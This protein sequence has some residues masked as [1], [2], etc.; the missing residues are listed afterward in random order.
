MQQS[1]VR[2]QHSLALLILLALLGDDTLDAQGT[3]LLRQPTVS[4]SSIAFTYGAD[5]WIVGRD[6][7]VARRLT[8]TPAVESDPHLSP[9]G[10]TVAFTSTR[11]GSPAVYTLPIEGGQPA[12]LTWHS[13]PARVRGWSPDGE[14]V[15]YA[16][17]RGTAP[18]GYDRLWTVSRNGG[19]STLLPAPF[20]HKASY[21]PDGATALSWTRSA[22]GT[23]SGGT[24]EADRTGRW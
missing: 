10:S 21:S 17:S 23:P 12:R 8:S 5:L 6:G 18:Q 16:S 20:G 4:S 13:S 14:H 3:R 1:F 22:A 19:P 7:G 11:S 24:T 15:L 2:I 9:D